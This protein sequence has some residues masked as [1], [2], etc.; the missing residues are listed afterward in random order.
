MPNAHRS[1]Q[2]V[3][4][5]LKNVKISAAHICFTGDAIALLG[6]YT[7]RDGV[8]HLDDWHWHKEQRGGAVFY[9]I[10]NLKQLKP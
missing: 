2:T 5:F 8:L 3:T 9:I 4:V 1:L 10:T 7:A 6:K